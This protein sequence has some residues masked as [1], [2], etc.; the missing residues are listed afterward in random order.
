MYVLEGKEYNRKE[1]YWLLVKKHQT[2]AF[3]DIPKYKQKRL[4]DG[5]T[6]EKALSY[7]WLIHTDSKGNCFAV[8]S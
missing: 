8:T 6:L 7:R 5:D 2:I 3:S 1:F 4:L